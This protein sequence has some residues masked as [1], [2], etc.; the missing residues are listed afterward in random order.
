MALLIR[1][2][3][4]EVG[5]N[6]TAEE[7]DQIHSVRMS[8]PELGFNEEARRAV[9]VHVAISDIK[10]PATNFANH[11]YRGTWPGRW[12]NDFN[13]K[14]VDDSPIEDKR[15]IA[16]QHGVSVTCGHMEIREIGIQKGTNACELRGID[17]VPRLA[18]H[19]PCG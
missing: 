1:E 6:W 15:K 7:L 18:R 13:L 4:D 14:R 10:D 2:L 9:P 11:R 19:A 3:R 17:F 16:R 12:N 8:E 5:G